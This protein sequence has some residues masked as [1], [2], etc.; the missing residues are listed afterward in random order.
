MSSIIDESNSNMYS[1]RMNSDVVFVIER[2]KFYAHKVIVA[3]RIKYFRTLFYKRRSVYPSKRNYEFSIFNILSFL[4]R[5]KNLHSVDIDRCKGKTK[6]IKGC[7]SKYLNF[8]IT[9]ANICFLQIGCD[10]FFKNR[11]SVIRRRFALAN[12][13]P[14]KQMT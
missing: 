9:L 2:K 4:K 5:N 6:S 7:T 8:K 10:D 14:I 13:Q 3:A 12:P 11:E 1:N